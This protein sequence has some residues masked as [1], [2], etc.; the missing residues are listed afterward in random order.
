M[1]QEE[2]K[3]IPFHM[4]SHLSMGN[5]HRTTYSD[6]SGRLGFCNISK[7]K[8]ISRRVFRLDGTWYENKEDFIKALG[9]IPAWT[10][11]K[12]GGKK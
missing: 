6:D 5:E 11:R 8:G 7:K 2:L 1:T 12:K 3:K 9:K 4:V 10:F